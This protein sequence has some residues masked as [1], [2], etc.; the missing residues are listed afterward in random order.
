[1]KQLECITRLMDIFG[2]S[3]ING[4][5]EIILIPKTNAYFCLEDVEDEFDVKCKLLEWCSRDASY[6]MPYIYPKS[7]EKYRDNVLEKINK[8]LGTNFSVSDMK[9]IYAVIGN[10]VNRDLTITFIK[11]NY[12]M[13]VLNK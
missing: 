13:D 3:F 10:G 9:E 4:K 2:D 11:S 8:Y 12:N 7:N 1:M 5:N 6:A